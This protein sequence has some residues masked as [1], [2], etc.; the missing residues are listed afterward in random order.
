MQLGA[1]CYNAEVVW[2]TEIIDLVGTRMQIS[3]LKYTAVRVHFFF[4]ENTRL[5]VKAFLLYKKVT[6]LPHKY[7]TKG[8]GHS[9]Q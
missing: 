1:K 9:L 5:Y 7:P 6:R 3:Q 4:L 8:N 2:R